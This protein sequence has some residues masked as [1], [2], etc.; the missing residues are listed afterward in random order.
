MVQ[1]SDA[2]HKTNNNKN[3]ALTLND[4]RVWV[5]FVDVYFYEKGT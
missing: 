4:N 5:I 2:R 1:D 3:S